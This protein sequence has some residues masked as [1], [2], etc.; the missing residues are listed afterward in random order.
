MSFSAA[1]S[2]G[3]ASNVQSSAVAVSNRRAADGDYMTGGFGRAA[4]KDTDGDYK[5]LATAQ[6]TSS[7]SVQ[8]ALTSLKTGG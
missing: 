7:S 2:S 4:I 6:T 5:P 8:A 1:G 3:N